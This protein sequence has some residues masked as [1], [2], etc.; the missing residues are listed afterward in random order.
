[1]DSGSTAAPPSTNPIAVGDRIG[2]FEIVGAL[3]AGG[4]GVVFEAHDPTLGRRVAIK[5]LH[6]E[7]GEADG[8][9]RLVREAQAL[10]RLSSP[11]VV[12]IFEAGVD[13]ERVFLA[14]EKVAG[15]DARAWAAAAPRSVAAICDVYRQAAIGLSVAHQ[16]GLVHRDV[17]PDNI[18]VGEDGRVRITDFGLVAAAGH[19][20]AAPDG[21]L[22]D[23][24]LAEDAATAPGPTPRAAPG[25]DL[26]AAPL[27]RTGALLGTPPY[28]APESHLR[29]ASDALSDQWS[30]CVAW[31][32]A[33]AGV[34]PFA[35]RTYR[36]LVAAISAGQISRGVDAI[37]AAVRP[38]LE[39]GLAVDP[40]ARWPS[41][42]ALIEALDQALRGA[43]PA[44]MVAVAPPA[45]GVTSPRRRW[46]W[47]AAG[48]ALVAAS[49][50]VAVARRASPS[51]PLMAVAVVPAAPPPRPIPRRLTTP[52]GCPYMPAFADAR[53][54]VFDDG[55]GDLW[56]VPV[57]GGAPR[58]LIDAPGEQWRAGRGRRDG[59]V[60]F[61]GA[62]GPAT[63]A[64]ASGETT[65]L[66]I[67]AFAVAASDAAIFYGRTDVAEIWRRAAG[68]EARVVALPD[69]LWQYA[70]SVSGD[71]RRVAITTH[72][73]RSTNTICV[74]ELG[75]AARPLDCLDRADV[76]MGRA[77]LTHDG[78][79]LYYQTRAGIRRRTLATK[80]DELWLPG[81]YAYGGIEISR[82]GR[83]LVYADTHPGE[84]VVAP[85]DAVDQPVL[86]EAGSWADAAPDGRWVHV[87]W[88]PDGSHE[89][90]EHAP[91]GTRRVLVTGLGPLQHPL[92][93][94]A[95]RT[96][97][98]E[99]SGAEGGIWTVD[100]RAYPPQRLTLRDGDSNPVWTRDGKVAFTRW[101]EH[102]RPNLMLADPADGSLDD[103]ARLAVH[104]Q[105]RLTIST[106]RTT[107]ELLLTGTDGSE[108]FAWDPVTRRERPIP[109]GG[110]PP[111]PVPSPD[112]RR[113]A[114]LSGAGVSEVPFPAGTR[115]RP[116]PRWAPPPCGAPERP[117]WDANGRL[118]IAYRPWVG[119]VYAVAIEP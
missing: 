13:G 81:A 24:P 114:I 41:V 115:Q 44:P 46:P 32:E 105:P 97:V 62:N 98:F 34:R 72:A 27:T 108:L 58:P 2:R 21:G 67:D 110:L 8:A 28:M 85:I 52:G 113:L 12:T 75:D 5:L 64:V 48:L 53:T 35:G 65:T 117:T 6:P 3:G 55:R 18:L 86:R 92:Y 69:G 76:I 40:A 26:L 16:A 82:D 99:V 63:L 84:I 42:A 39:R 109:I 15:S 103:A 23:R 7:Q 14:M 50:G 118:H 22:D 80:A 73:Q 30:L 43:A 60:I 49:A 71:G 47:L 59:E 45:G 106:V 36:E 95:G 20:G 94:P 77:A 79:T 19:G 57:T 90:V 17:K 89:L 31:W 33:L 4:G 116:V 107:G 112:G 78:A 51:S 74:V 83:T 119:D 1:M 25:G 29:G 88:N 96:V 111:N 66:G 100:V 93:D 10:A 104:P 54:V 102:K 11:H 37:P 91:D 38:V 9:A 61:V 56:A 101:D 87:R 68:E 70:L